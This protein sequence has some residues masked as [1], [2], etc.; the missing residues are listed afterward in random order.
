MIIMVELGWVATGRQAG[1]H[2]VEAVAESLHLIHNYRQ[3]DRQ[4]ETRPGMFF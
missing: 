1:M 3:A 2:S 4:I